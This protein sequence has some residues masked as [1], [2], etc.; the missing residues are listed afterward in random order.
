M[1]DR[2]NS[3]IHSLIKTRICVLLANLLDKS[4]KVVVPPWL[5]KKPP[6]PP[7]TLH[8]FLYDICKSKLG[9][10]REAIKKE[11]KVMKKDGEKCQKKFEKCLKKYDK[12]YTEW[13]D[14]L[15]HFQ[16]ELYEDFVEV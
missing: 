13:M 1:Y 7:A 3:D 11:I 15:N 16:R 6:Q 2:G 9:N 4:Q 5:E 12:A 8:Y 14:G 10:D